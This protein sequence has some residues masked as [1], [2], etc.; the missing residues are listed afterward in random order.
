M[1]VWSEAEFAA[2]MTSRLKPLTRFAY[3]LTADIGQAEDLVQT[4]LVSLYRRS[5]RAVPDSPEAYIRTVIVNAYRQQARRRRVVEYFL[6]PGRDFP[7]PAH[8][9]SDPDIHE[10]A[11]MQQAIAKLSPRER[12]VVALRYYADYSETQIAEAMS[13]HPGTV[14]RLASRAL[15][16]LSQSLPSYPDAT[17]LP[18]GSNREHH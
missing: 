11:S 9:T 5:R 3:S 14:K 13:V 6:P 1:S 4:A 16:K 18:A 15:A 7:E 10:R 8:T 17:A 2:F 12:T